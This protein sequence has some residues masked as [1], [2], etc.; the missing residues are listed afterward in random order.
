MFGCVH[1]AVCV[2]VSACV[3]KTQR[4][5]ERESKRMREQERGGGDILSKCSVFGKIIPNRATPWG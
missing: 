3:C 4:E 1:V 5:T 2:C